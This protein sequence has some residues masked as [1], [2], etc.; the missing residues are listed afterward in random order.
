MARL[1]PAEA[2]RVA[3]LLRAA[4]RSHFKGEQYGNGAWGDVTI[5][6]F[7]PRADLQVGDFTGVPQNLLAGL[8]IA[9]DGELGLRTSELRAMF[10]TVLRSSVAEYRRPYGFL[11]TRSEHSGINPGGGALRFAPGLVEMLGKL[12]P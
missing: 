8:A 10:T 3:D 9:Y 7:D 11:S 2:S 1:E 4:V 12:K 5:F 6:G